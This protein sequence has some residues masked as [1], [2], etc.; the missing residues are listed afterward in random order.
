VRTVERWWQRRRPA[1]ATSTVRNGG[2]SGGDLESFTIKR[3]MSWDGLLF[4]GSKLSAVVL[5]YN[6]C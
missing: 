5:N 1:R 3:E 2:E 6:R 4:I